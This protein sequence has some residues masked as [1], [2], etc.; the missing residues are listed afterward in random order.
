MRIYKNVGFLEIFGFDGLLLKIYHYCAQS[1]YL[2]LQSDVF[3]VDYNT[4]LL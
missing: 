3:T 1:D 4:L 2:N